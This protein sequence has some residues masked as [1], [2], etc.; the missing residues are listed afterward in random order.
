MTEAL[1]RLATA[2]L[3]IDEMLEHEASL[4]V[5]RHAYAMAGDCAAVV[6]HRDGAL[7]HTIA[8]FMGYAVHCN[9]NDLPRWAVGRQHNVLQRGSLRLIR[10]AR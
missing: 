8:T 4:R 2:R 9:A 6:L 1:R 5:G 10:L 7:A 3:R